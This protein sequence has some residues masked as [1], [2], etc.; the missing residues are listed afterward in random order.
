MTV[1]T[2]WKCVDNKLGANFNKVVA[3][4]ADQSSA[5][6]T[7][8]TPSAPFSLGERAHGDNGSEWIF[9][10]ASTTV[11][12]YMAVVI[13]NNFKANNITSALIASNVYAIGL[14]QF[15]DVTQADAGEYFWAC[16]KAVGGAGAR[17]ASSAGKGVALYISGTPGA[18]TSS[19]TNNKM[20]GLS[21]VASIGTSASNP[22]EVVIYDYIHAYV[23]V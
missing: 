16:L 11:T 3:V 9:V 22:G 8:E 13:D 17:V 1:K 10:Q 2:N 7:P 20:V 4:D 6:F 18:F 5:D 23:S 15:N 12:Q 14:A 19:A 21:F